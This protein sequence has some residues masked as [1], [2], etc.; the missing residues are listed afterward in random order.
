MKEQYEIKITYFVRSIC[1]FFTMIK[2]IMA[3]S[4]TKET[5]NMNL[6]NT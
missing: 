1:L 2:I 6:E 4:S 3:I 5:K